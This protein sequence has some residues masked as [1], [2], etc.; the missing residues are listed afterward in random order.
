MK[1]LKP[2]LLLAIVVGLGYGVWTFLFPSPEKQ[3]RKSLTRLAETASFTANEKPLTRLGSINAL[4][5]FFH[6]N[7]VVIIANENYS[8]SLNGKAELREAAA[9]ARVAAQSIRVLLTDPRITVEDSSHATAMV[10]ATAYVDGD[11]NPQ[12][13]ILKMGFERLD[14]KWLIRRVDPVALGSF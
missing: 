1:A 4:P 7:A 10:T 9:G 2:I 11:P 3:I 12:L 8:A 13:Q 6:T 14:R 5:T